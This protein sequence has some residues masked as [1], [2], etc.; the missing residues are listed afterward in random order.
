LFK[1]KLKNKNK[2]KI[3]ILALSPEINIV[4]TKNKK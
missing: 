1:S 3:K 2:N 4:E